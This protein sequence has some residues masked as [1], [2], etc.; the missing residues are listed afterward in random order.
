MDGIFQ[1]KTAINGDFLEESSEKRYAG[2]M[3]TFSTSSSRPLTLSPSTE[4]QVY[5][6]LG[7]AMA[8][9]VV[10]VLAGF[11]ALSLVGS[12][13][14]II[15]VIAEL[16][17]ILSAGLWVNLRP[18]NYVLFG[19]FPLLSGF[20]FTPYIVTILAA[21]V[22][23]ASILLNALLST[24][25]MGVAAAV[26]AKTTGIN[27]SGFSRTLLFALLGLVA[28]GV[29]QIFFPALRVPQAEMMLSGLGII[30]F[31]AFTA[32]DLQ[33]IQTAGRAGANPFMLAI[34]LYLD[35]FNLFLYIVRFML[36]ISGERR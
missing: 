10:G 8:L 4:A 18:L 31:A 33:R 34:S 32:Y 9:T 7:V 11:Q 27:L 30:I 2:S 26:F 13:L 16:A 35:I 20:T 3:Q 29:L 21:Y 19:L 22:N 14:L 15:C 12:P 24:A 25:L 17:I 28:F 23:G 6:L 5:L 36:A 1:S